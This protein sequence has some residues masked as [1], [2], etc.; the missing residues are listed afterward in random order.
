[1]KIVSGRTIGWL[2]KLAVSFGETLWYLKISP[3][4]PNTSMTEP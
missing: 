3:S 1:M 2:V 4:N